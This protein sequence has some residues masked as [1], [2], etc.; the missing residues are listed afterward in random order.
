MYGH[1]C[2]QIARMRLHNSP[3][4]VGNGARHEASLISSPPHTAPY[5]ARQKI[6]RLHSAD[7]GESTQ[8]RISSRCHQRQPARAFSVTG[9]SSPRSYL[10]PSIRRALLS[11]QLCCQQSRD[12][13]GNV[14]A[15]ISP[16]PLVFYVFHVQTKVAIKPLLRIFT[17]FLFNFNAPT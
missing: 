4:T 13:D 3:S 11:V 12:V 8:L 6:E 17:L 2:S 7:E 10:Q 9:S 15:T 14:T 5:H 1:V 16:L